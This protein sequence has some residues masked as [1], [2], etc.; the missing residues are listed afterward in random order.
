MPTYDYFCSANNRTIEVTHKMSEDIATWEEL[1]NKAGIE[2]GDTPVNA[3]IKRLIT[4][5]A[6]ISNSGSEPPC[7]SGSCCP[8]GSCGF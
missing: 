3:T 6:I 5:G 8:G 2:T 1:C 4:G 7:A